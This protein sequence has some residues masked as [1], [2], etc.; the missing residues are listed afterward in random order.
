VRFAHAF[1][2]RWPVES[3]LLALRAAVV[4]GLSVMISGKTA[5]IA[6]FGDPTTNFRAPMIYNPCFEQ[7]DIRCGGDADGSP[8]VSSDL[9]KSSC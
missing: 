6:H 7:A 8:D 1:A 3:H 9:A 4:S 2:T 5:L